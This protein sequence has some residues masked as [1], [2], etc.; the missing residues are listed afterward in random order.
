MILHYPRIVLLIA[1]AGVNKL[2]IL[3]RNVSKLNNNKRVDN[4][5]VI[6][7]RLQAM[8][9][10]QTARGASTNNRILQV[11]KINHVM[12]RSNP[13]YNQVH[14]QNWC[15]IKCYTIVTITL[16]VS[17]RKITRNFICWFKHEKHPTEQACHDKIW[18]IT[19]YL[20]S[21]PFIW[22]QTL[23]YLYFCPK[24]NLSILWL[25]PWSTRVLTAS[26]PCSSA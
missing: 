25:N 17:V 19:L 1:P 5:T 8:I 16:V 7:K 4:L 11:T 14:L 6:W 13:I 18:W 10:W 12:N 21:I 26:T 15:A 20:S 2:L 24:L 9:P 23:W 3:E 22:H